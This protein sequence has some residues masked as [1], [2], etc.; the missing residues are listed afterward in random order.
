MNTFSSRMGVP[1]LAKLS[2]RGFGNF[3]LIQQA[4]QG[5][6]AQNIGEKGKHTSL[7]A[8]HLSMMRQNLLGS[9]QVLRN[10]SMLFN[11]GLSLRCFGSKSAPIHSPF[12]LI[13][14]YCCR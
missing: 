7:S 11:Q 3:S 5:H 1:G 12:V 6:V 10:Q 9:G 4:A 14:L 8:M 13:T 2:A